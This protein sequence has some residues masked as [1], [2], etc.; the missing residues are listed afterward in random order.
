MGET[1]R[2]LLMKNKMTHNVLWNVQLVFLGSLGSSL[3][4]PKAMGTQNCLPMEFQNLWKELYNGLLERLLVTLPSTGLQ[5]RWSGLLKLQ[6]SET[7]R[8]SSKRICQSIANGYWQEN[9]LHYWI[10][11]SAKQTMVTLGWCPTFARGLISWAPCRSPRFS[12]SSIHMPLWLRIKW[13]FAL[14]LDKLSG[15]PWGKFC[16]Y[17]WWYS[18][19]HCWGGQPRLA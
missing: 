18:S 9:G 16:G 4:K 12:L 2:E 3:S 1:A 11:W 13:G 15:T 5:L 6:S 19:Y 10:L 17:C 8:R 14:L 7:R